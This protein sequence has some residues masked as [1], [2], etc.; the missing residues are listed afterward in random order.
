MAKKK[1]TSQEEELELE[2]LKEENNRLIAENAKLRTETTSI[3]T[4]EFEYEGVPYELV[5]KGFIHNGKVVKSAEI[6]QNLDIQKY[7]VETDSGLIRIAGQ[8]N[9]SADEDDD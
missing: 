2:V 5:V 8:E 3:V 7:L 1:I 9:L 6:R 4:A